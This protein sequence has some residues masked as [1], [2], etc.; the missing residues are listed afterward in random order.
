VRNLATAPAFA[1]RKRE[2]EQ[3]MVS[4]LKAQEDPRMFGRGEAF[5]QYPYANAG[6]R[7]FHECYMKGEKL[8]AGWVEESDFE[9]QP[10]D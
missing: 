4:E 1:G 10:L 7:N 5:E 8:E 6:Q 3:Q 9:K 2:L